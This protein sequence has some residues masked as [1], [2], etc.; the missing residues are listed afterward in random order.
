[1]V[2]SLQDLKSALLSHVTE[3]YYSIYC[4]TLRATQLNC[5]HNI[6]GQ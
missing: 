2:G 1:M 5:T 4:M 6:K 3:D